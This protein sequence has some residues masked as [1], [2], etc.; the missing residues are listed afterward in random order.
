MQ[1]NSVRSLMSTPT[2]GSSQ[3]EKPHVGVD[4]SDFTQCTGVHRPEEIAQPP[5][6]PLGP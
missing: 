5:R 1:Q 4:P 2:W 6:T 3:E